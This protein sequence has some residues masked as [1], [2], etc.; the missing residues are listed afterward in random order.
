MCQIDSAQ[1]DYGCQRLSEGD[2]SREEIRK[3]VWKR[4]GLYFPFAKH[5]LSW[6]RSRKATVR[7]DTDEG[8]SECK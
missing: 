7:H 6:P 4:K 2:R 5:E 8:Q 1:L 3:R